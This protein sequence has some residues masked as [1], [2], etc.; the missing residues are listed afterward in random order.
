MI[1]ISYGAYF[2]F[3]RDPGT[4]PRGAANRPALPRERARDRVDVKKDGS[5]NT[6]ISRAHISFE[7]GAE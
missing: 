3:A 2:R 4:I 7:D 6:D 5:V 1:S